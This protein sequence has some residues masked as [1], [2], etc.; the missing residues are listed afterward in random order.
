M[1]TSLEK[2]TVFINSGD[3]DK[4]KWPAASDFEIS[5]PLMRRVVR[6]VLKYASVGRRNDDSCIALFIDGIRHVISAG[7]F[8]GAF[9]ILTPQNAAQ[10]NG[11]FGINEKYEVDV[12]DVIPK[13]NLLH[14]RILNL[15]GQPLEMINECQFILELWTVEKVSVIGESTLFPQLV[16]TDTLY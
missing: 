7:I 14:F 3:R 12:T 2:H 4:S 6:V 11:V 16:N 1:E 15:E 10:G 8:H 13:L 5:F 9:C